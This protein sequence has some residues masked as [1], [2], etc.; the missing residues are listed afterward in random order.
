MEWEAKYGFERLA[1]FYRVFGMIVSMKKDANKAKLPKRNMS[2]K[3]KNE[4]ALLLLLH[5]KKFQDSIK[6][7]RLRFGLPSEGF[8][9]E[10]SA[11]EFLTPSICVSI[12]EA[13][14]EILREY[15]LPIHF[16]KPLFKLISHNEVFSPL[17]NFSIRVSPSAKIDSNTG[18]AMQYVQEISLVTFKPLDTEEQR[19]ALQTLK[20]FW[21]RFFTPQI[22]KRT[23]LREPDIKKK[24]LLV[25]K[26]EKRKMK[27]TVEEDP[28]L[29]SVRKQSGES[30]YEDTKRK[31]PGMIHKKGDKS[32]SKNVAEEL[33]GTKKKAGAARTAYSRL[34]K[35]MGE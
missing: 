29:A 9:D 12:I 33:L 24:Y 17:G 5:T 6:A 19:V 15:K 32:T 3:L 22:T 14:N 20:S 10:L 4:D 25:E 16:K 11:T 21:N 31:N 35:K 13:T 2:S 1:V 23:N 28:Y 18:N 7:F 26:M 34:K 27:E 8:L 30:I